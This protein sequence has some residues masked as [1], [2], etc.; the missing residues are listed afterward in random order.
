[1]RNGLG[2]SK[3][4]N[5]IWFKGAH[6]K[7]Q[8]R[9][10]RTWFEN[11]FYCILQKFSLLSRTAEEME[12]RKVQWDLDYIAAKGSWMLQFPTIEED[13]EE[14]LNMVAGEGSG[15]LLVWDRLD[16]LMKDYKTLKNAQKGLVKIL[17]DLKFHLS[18]VFQRYIDVNDTRAK[19]S[20]LL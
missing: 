19:M 8:S 3:K 20:R 10:V 13:E 11:C 6:R 16:R 1:M 9:K 5:E 15:T 12:L 18:M 4:R 14:M 2:W 7:E 17:D